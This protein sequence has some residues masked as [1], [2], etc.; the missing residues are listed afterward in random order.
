MLLFHYCEEIAPIHIKQWAKKWNP[1]GE[2]E[3]S[4]NSKFHT[5]KLNWSSLTQ[6]S[7]AV[8][9]QYHF[10]LFFNRI[11]QQTAHYHIRGFPASP[12][13]QDL[14]GTW[15]K[16]NTRGLGPRPRVLQFALDTLGCRNRYS[17]KSCRNGIHRRTCKHILGHYCAICA[18]HHRWGHASIRRT[19][20]QLT[21]RLCRNLAVGRR[22]P[23][24]EQRVFKVGPLFTGTRSHWCH[25]KY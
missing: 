4:R 25:T 3:I 10:S 15:A 5:P 22:L 23:C 8:C 7:F 24:H 17:T 12:A 19:I 14:L 9:R 18:V 11:A 6:V 1:L 16:C 2:M 20:W 13:E 21:A